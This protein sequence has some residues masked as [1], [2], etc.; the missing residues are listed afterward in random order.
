MKIQIWSTSFSPCPPPRVTLLT[1]PEYRIFFK[2]Q[3]RQSG[4]SSSQSPAF[5][6][7]SP[8]REYFFIQPT[9]G[10]ETTQLRRIF[11][12]DAITGVLN[13]YPARSLAMSPPILTIFTWPL[14]LQVQHIGNRYRQ[15]Q[16]RRIACPKA[17]THLKLTYTF[18]SKTRHFLTPLRSKSPVLSSIGTGPTHN[19]VLGARFPCHIRIDTV[20]L[21]KRSP[22]SCL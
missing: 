1:S 13:Q 2:F 15:R 20:P 5:P 10:T 12:P 18:P 21:A 9:R 8:S 3:H 19:P 4:Q 6:N 14:R 17:Y 7:R 16:D 11:F 22:P